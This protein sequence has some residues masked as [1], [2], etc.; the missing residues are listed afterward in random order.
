MLVLCQLS[1]IFKHTANT[2]FTMTGPRPPEIAP[3]TIHGDPA[4]IVPPKVEVQKPSLM[5][6]WVNCSTAILIVT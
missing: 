4:P 5:Q 2:I 3:S 1:F 6:A